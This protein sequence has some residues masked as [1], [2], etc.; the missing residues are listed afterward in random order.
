M[1]PS[2]AEPCVPQETPPPRVPGDSNPVW[3][4]ATPGI[5]IAC[6]GPGAE[7]PM[8]SADRSLSPG[9]RQPGTRGSQPLQRW[10]GA[11]LSI[12][13]L[14]FSTCSSAAAPGSWHLRWPAP[15]NA[16]KPPYPL[17]PRNAF[18]FLHPVQRAWRHSSQIT[19]LIAALGASCLLAGYPVI[20]WTSLALLR[21]NFEHIRVTMQ[22]ETRMS[23]DSV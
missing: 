8:E 13:I 9:L 4:A 18:L 11:R 3:G 14:S 21:C 5:R 20:L 15:E 16:A 1:R 12:F 2:A 23:R 10:G 22:G 7:A 6:Q 19:S 17:P